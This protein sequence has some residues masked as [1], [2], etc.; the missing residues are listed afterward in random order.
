MDDNKKEILRTY[1]SILNTPFKVYSIDN[2]KLMVPISPYDAIY[3]LVGLLIIA[4]ADYVYPGNIKFMYKFIV[5]P[6]LIR[7]VLTKVKLDGK[8]PHKFFFGM[9][10]YVLTNKKREFFRPIG[11]Q[12]LKSFKNQQITCLRAARKQVFYRRGDTK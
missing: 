8:K 10:I 7:F 6:L 9:L 4:A 5:F 2:M 3:Y 12:T 1:T 11:K